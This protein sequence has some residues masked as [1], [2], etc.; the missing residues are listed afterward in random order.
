[1]SR[2]GNFSPERSAPESRP[3]FSAFRVPVMS[4]STVVDAVDV[5]ISIEPCWLATDK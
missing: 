4:A 2:S 3:R 1:M 5:S